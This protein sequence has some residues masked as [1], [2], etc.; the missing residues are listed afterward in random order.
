MV[1]QRSSFPKPLVQPAGVSFEPDPE[2]FAILLRNIERHDL[3][4]VVAIPKGIWSKTTTIKLIAD[5]TLGMVAAAVGVRPTSAIETEV[6]VVSI[7]DA[8]SE[9]S[10]ERLA[11]IKL[12]IEGA[13]VEAVTGALEFLKGR[14][15]IS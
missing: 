7:P 9:F 11:L 2:N 14:N 12:D 10:V 13:E 6:Q 15:I 5:G 4:N 8:F 1:I 3:R